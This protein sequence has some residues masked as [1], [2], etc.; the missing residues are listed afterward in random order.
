M[1]E[2]IALVDF[3]LCLQRQRLLEFGE[4][5]VIS[6]DDEIYNPDDRS[7]II[8]RGWYFKD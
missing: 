6:V 1:G 7:N 4:Y 2:H 5:I 8:R 3:V